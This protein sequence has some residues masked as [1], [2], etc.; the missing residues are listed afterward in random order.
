M[1]RWGQFLSF[2]SLHPTVR[3]SSKAHLSAAGCNYR[4]DID[5]LRAV[6]VLGVVLYHAFPALAPGGF[7]GVDIFFVISGYLISGVIFKDLAAGTFSI[8]DFY[9]HRIRR[10]FPA[11]A[12]VLVVSWVLGWYFLVPQDFKRFADAMLGGACFYGNFI[13]LEV[14]YFQ[15]PEVQRPLLHLWSL[16]VEEQFYLLW[17]LLLWAAWRWKHSATRGLIVFILLGSLFDSVVRTPISPKT[18]FYYPD[19]RFWELAIGGILA[20]FGLRAGTTALLTKRSRGLASFAGAALILG[21]L[22]L[23]DAELPWPGWRALFPTL[24][25]A[26]LLAAGPGGFVNRAILSSRPAVFIGKISYPWYLWHWPLLVFDRAT[27]W[28]VPQI[29]VDAGAVIASL[30]LAF[31]TYR[32]IERRVRFGPSFTER[33]R[34]L[35]PLAA[36]SVPA[37]L[38]AVVLYWK[39]L[40]GR[41]PA[42]MQAVLTPS[43]WSTEGWKCFAEGKDLNVSGCI[44][45]KASGGDNQPLIVL[46]GDSHGFALYTGLRDY[47]RR[48]AGFRLAIFTK[49]ACPFFAHPGTK[50]TSPGCMEFNAQV[51]TQVHSLNPDLVILNADWAATKYFLNGRL[52]E[53]AIHE[54]ILALQERG[55]RRIAVV[56]LVPEWTV[57][58]PNVIVREWLRNAGS[59]PERSR[60]GLFEDIYKVD[61]SVRR[62]VEETNAAYVPVLDKLCT[63]EGCLLMAGREPLQMDESHLTQAGSRLVMDLIAPQLLMSMR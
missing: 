14:G 28:G 29:W 3:Q 56:G 5:G 35:A 63:T 49:G 52:D 16:G 54:S 17:P 53:Q 27:P 38:A 13:G 37:V 57:R 18:A 4:R 33:L 46:W 20:Y 19:T 58:Q 39:G 11:L 23:L 7:S 41:F 8:T 42:D 26:L 31:A 22:A 61:A 10:I 25:T 9:A 34:T 62:L 44:D 32:F 59:I 30:G 45:A 40:P 6:A 36:M 15:A 12:L 2:Y 60:L 21:S 24:G 43:G 55:N 1:A 51:R 48:H 47:Q 50:W